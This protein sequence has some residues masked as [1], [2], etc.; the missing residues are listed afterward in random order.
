MLRQEPVQANNR[1]DL[2]EK[3][4]VASGGIVFTTIQKFS[5]DDGEII[6]PLLSE[7]KNIVVIADEAHRSQ[8]GFKAKTI[9]VKDENGNII[10]KRT[11]YGFAKY[12]RD[13]LPNATFTGFT[14]TPIELT[15]RNT[16]AVFGSYID[17]YDISQA[18]DDRATVKIYYESRLAKVNLTEEGRKLI[19]ELDKEIEQEDLTVTQQAKAKWTKL[20]AI[21]GS[22]D[23]L[24]NV[25][26]DALQHFEQ[27]QEV[28]KG[29]AMF[30]SMSRRIAVDMYNE[31]IRLHPA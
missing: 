19:K 28:F 22:P 26:R 10:G 17:I 25:A 6:Y 16:P 9:D 2:R 15:D 11:A 5:P 7:R 18:Q 8:Y 1:D 4:K 3:L 14:G 29:K 27:R 23:R 31:I 30:V 12:V 21:V 20:E 24:K 13:A